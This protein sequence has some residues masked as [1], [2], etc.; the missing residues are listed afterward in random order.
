MTQAP[1]DGGTPQKV[2][3][4][5]LFEIN[6]IITPVLAIALLLMGFKYAQAE[7]SSRDIQLINNYIQRVTQ[8]AMNGYYQEIYEAANRLQSE[9]TPECLQTLARAQNHLCP[10]MDR[11][12]VLNPT[13]V[14]AAS[15]SH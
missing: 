5:E 11:L 2:D 12:S 6:A 15:I 13:R 7:C 14:T 8:L 3:H 4:S 9:I 1:V 10:R